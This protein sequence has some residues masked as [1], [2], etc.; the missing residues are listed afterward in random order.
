MVRPH[1]KQ[2]KENFKDHAVRVG[3]FIL[4]CYHTSFLQ[5]LPL[6]IDL[7]ARLNESLITIVT[8]FIYI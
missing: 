7:I 5:L 2:A 1:F 6:T 3:R 8:L 4:L